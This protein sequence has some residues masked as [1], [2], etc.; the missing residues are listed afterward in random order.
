MDVKAI[1]TQNGFRPVKEYDYYSHY[2]LTI[3]EYNQIIDEK[4]AMKEE[5]VKLRKI[6]HDNVDKVNRNTI[7]QKSTLK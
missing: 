5:I 1:P 2:I 4:R 6:S 7:Q 3:D